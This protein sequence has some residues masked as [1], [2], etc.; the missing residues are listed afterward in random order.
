MDV[1]VEDRNSAGGDMDPGE[2]LFALEW[3]V[4][5]VGDVQAEWI[6]FGGKKAAGRIKAPAIQ[7]FE[8][9]GAR[10][11]CGRVAGDRNT[12]VAD[13]G[14]LR[15]RVGGDALLAGKVRHDKVHQLH[16]PEGHEF[17]GSLIPGGA[18]IVAHLGLLKIGK[19]EGPLPMLSINP[20]GFVRPLSDG[21]Q[22]EAGNGGGADGEG[23]G[24][25]AKRIR[26]DAGFG[27]GDCK[28]LLIRG[29]GVAG[30][31]VE[32]SAGEE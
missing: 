15:D 26:E 30:L 16:E 9:I 10:R 7:P 4:V 22:G 5:S 29:V 28:I 27:H 31:G 1:E 32:A 3:N 23:S 17:C 21:L 24:S 11:R 13:R 18:G 20:L 8:S 12:L 6:V 25:G 2:Q 19:A 14:R